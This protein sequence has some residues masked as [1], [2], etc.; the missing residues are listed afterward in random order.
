MRIVISLRKARILSE[1]P[2]ASKLSLS[3]SDQ[4]EKWLSDS[5]NTKLSANRAVAAI[6][7]TYTWLHDNVDRRLKE[8]VKRVLFTI[9]EPVDRRPNG[10]LGVAS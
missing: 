7:A 10:H 2:E 9:S 8:G 5:S 3:P 1:V 6:V 4:R